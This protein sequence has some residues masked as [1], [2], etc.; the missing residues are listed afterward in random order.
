LT[1]DYYSGKFSTSN[2]RFILI[3]YH[4]DAHYL[5]G[6]LWLELV[7]NTF[8]WLH[9]S[10]NGKRWKK[11]TAF[12]KWVVKKTK[13][14][15]NVWQKAD[16]GVK[17]IPKR[18]LKPKTWLILLFQFRHITACYFIALFAFIFYLIS[19]PHIQLSH[20]SFHPFQCSCS[21]WDIAQ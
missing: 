12:E 16:L 6:I 9:Y 2:K 15:K 20:N 8:D 13:V 17:I 3:I 5:A 1:S 4:F 18:N 7:E 21:N 11:Q 19:T 14:D 10:G